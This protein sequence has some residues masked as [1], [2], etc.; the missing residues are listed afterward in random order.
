VRL[1]MRRRAKALLIAALTLGWSLV[2]FPATPS[3]DCKRAVTWVEKAVCSDDALAT[4]D[5]RLA[6]DYQR[7]LQSPLRSTTV[8]AP[9]PRE[10]VLVVDQR[11]WLAAR[12]PACHV[13]ESLE[14]SSSALQ[15]LRQFYELRIDALQDAFPSAEGDATSPNQLAIPYRAL[16]LGNE[17][18]LPNS[19]A[20]F[21]GQVWSFHLSTKG[22]GWQAVHMDPQTGQL[23]TLET[24]S[25]Q[26]RFLY[27]NQHYVVMDVGTYLLVM[28]S[29]GS[30]QR[31]I[32]TTARPW[33]TT[34]VGDE[35]SVVEDP[36]HDPLSSPPEILERFDLGTGQLRFANRD[37]LKGLP[38]FWGDR[39]VIVDATGG[40]SVFSKTL[41]KIAYAKVVT[42][43]E[44]KPAIQ[45]T[46]AGDLLLLGLPNDKTIAM[47]LQTMQVLSDLGLPAAS[48]N[49]L[50]A[51]M[52]NLLFCLPSRED[53]L[54][55]G[56]LPER[57]M[58][59]FNLATQRLV[60]Q[61]K[62]EAD[63]I[64]LIGGVLLAVNHSVVTFYRLDT[65]ALENPSASEWAI[66]RSHS[67][68]QQAFA[69]SGSIYDA[70]AARGDADILPT[71]GVERSDIRSAAVDE[72]SW[73]AE[74]IAGQREGLVRLKQLHDAYPAD[75]RI[76]RRY[77]GALLID[78]AMNSTTTSLE[79]AE[80]LGVQVPA[81]LLG[82]W[83]RVASRPLARPINLG[84][85][86]NRLYPRGDRLFV[87]EGRHPT[88]LASFDRA[89]LEHQADYP[90]TSAATDDDN[91]WVSDV[92]YDGEQIIVWLGSDSKAVTIDSVSGSVRRRPL[93]GAA[94]H[95]LTTDQGFVVCSDDDG[96]QNYDPSS[97]CRALDRQLRRRNDF[98]LSLPFTL[99]GDTIRDP[100]AAIWALSKMKTL[101]RPLLP[102]A[103][104]PQWLLRP[105]VCDSD[106]RDSSV[107][108]LR[109]GSAPPHWRQAN[110]PPVQY[111]TSVQIS[112]SQATAVVVDTTRISQRFVGLD[113]GHNVRSV[114]L[115]TEGSWWRA[116]AVVG[117]YLLVAHNRELIVYDL[118]A[119]QLAGVW[120][121]A[122]AASPDS[123]TD[124][125]DIESDGRHVFLVTGHQLT[126]EALAIDMD[127]LRAFASAG[128]A[129]RAFAHKRAYD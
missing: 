8:P 122:K 29:D 107:H 24:L 82:A 2:A 4:L 11:R 49:A 48:G 104:S 129:L 91:L 128:V 106:P 124:I 96:P 75:Q 57:P 17:P 14:T 62:L 35:L 25:A 85:F 79:A 33:I 21:N 51:A 111:G 66:L 89:T 37:Q 100:E 6:I 70:L 31:Q 63:H 80:R 19:T 115:Q 41:Q 15:C 69:A 93:P 83:N 27:A 28:H 110:L 72:A 99:S 36:P 117:D 43:E 87:W 22:D 71:H 90:I 13:K 64:D 52:G 26:P 9:Q 116:W 12:D 20:I 23:T 30:G 119:H 88:I 7:S 58:S 114:L 34:I 77:A 94:S 55:A 113:L 118:A 1:C 65:A 5:A 40:V 3:F 54:H 76:S 127:D 32:H 121:D 39:V 109:L 61:V 98:A 50:Y 73:L 53:W 68:A 78:F 47:N 112:D 59:I 44:V 103:L 86:V 123:A 126:E 105:A 97:T 10:N 60:G 120:R 102:S 46:V 95:V 16:S 38:R 67:R 18:A 84:S 101:V 81:T 92:T 108:Y 42:N 56:P 45:M 125:K 74:T